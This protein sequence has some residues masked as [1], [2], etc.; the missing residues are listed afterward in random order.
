MMNPLVNFFEKKVR[1]PRSLAVFITLAI[2][3]AVF[4]GLV[5]LLVAEIVVGANYFAKVVPEHLITL[6]N[7]LEQ[8]FASQ[9]IPLYHQLTNLFQSL[10]A[11]QQDTIMSNIE[12]VGKTVGTTVGGF[13]QNLFGNI[14]NIISW[15]PNA[16]TVLI[17]SLL[18]T[19]FISKDWYKFI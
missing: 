5:T 3:F 14:P 18:A 15:F 2:F 1:M 10:D 17:F 8:V 6:I 11:G 13:I 7:Y 12:D 9:I 4:A 19:F 16:A